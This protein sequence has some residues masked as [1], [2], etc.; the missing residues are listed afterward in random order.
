[1]AKGRRI[2]SSLRKVAEHYG[3]RYD[4]VRKDWRKKGMPG[5]PGAWDLDEIERWQKVRQSSMDRSGKLTLDGRSVSEQSA[6]GPVDKVTEAKTRAT[7]ADARRKDADAR[8]KE[9]QA[10]KAENEGL[11][12]LDEVEEFISTWLAEARNILKAVPVK[13]RRFGLEVSGALDQE[14][15]LALHAI[16]KKSERLV[17]L[18]RD[19]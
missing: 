3:V 5:S 2:V 13:M 15:D 4:T 11:V 18:R 7:L 8:I 9:I 1:M 17:E 12:E 10:L 6:E 16:R 14:L 19:A